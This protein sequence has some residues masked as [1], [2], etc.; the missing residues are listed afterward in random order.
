MAAFPVPSETR[1]LSPDDFVF[2]PDSMAWKINRHWTGLLYGPAAALLQ[3]AHPRVAQGVAEHSAFQSDALGRLQRTLSA[4]NQITFGTHE[5]A[6]EM[7]ALIGRMHGGVRGRT[8][9]GID[10]EASYSAFEPELMLWVLGTLIEA[11]L[12]GYREVFGEVSAVDKQAF[13]EDFRRFGSYFGLDAAFGPQTYAEWDN[14]YRIKKQR[15]GLHPLCREVARHVV[16]PQA[17][18]MERL[19]GCAFDFI[20]IEGLDPETRSRLGFQS[21][22]HSRI[23]WRLATGFARWFVPRGPKRLTCYPES[24]AAQKALKAC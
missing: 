6:A 24:Y 14:A 22:W 3:I 17:H 4:V 16:Y 19:L 18:W 7:K 12:L 2:G 21:S 9:P 20:A 1:Q 15:M 11:S 13:Y 23:R 5:E 10:G 8:A